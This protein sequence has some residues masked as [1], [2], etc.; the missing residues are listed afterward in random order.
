M[1]HKII[2]GEVVPKGIMP[3]GRHKSDRP[4]LHKG[5]SLP[6]A[7][8]E[9][10]GVPSAYINRYIKKL[11]ETEDVGLHTI[12]ILRHGHVIAEGAA[13]PYRTDCR[14]VVHSI[15]KSVTGMAIGLL[16]KEGKVALWEK[17][18]DI[19][20]EEAKDASEDIRSITVEQLLTMGTGVLFDEAHSIMEEDWVRAFFHSSCAFKPGEGFKYNS[21]NSYMLSAIVQKRTGETLL[22]YLKPRL[23]GPLGIRFVQWQ[24]CPKGIT[25]GGWGLALYLEDMAKLGQLYLNGGMWEV[26]GKMQEIIPPSWVERST[27]PQNWNRGELPKK[28][29]GYQLWVTDRG[30]LFNGMF[31]QYILVYPAHDMVIALT[32]GSQKSILAGE[33]L[34]VTDSFFRERRLFSDGPLP[35]NTAKAR[36]LLGL[37]GSME[38]FPGKGIPFGENRGFERRFLKALS[39]RVYRLSPFPLGGLL[40]TVVQCMQGRLSKGISAVSFFVK[41][42]ALELSFTEGEDTN[43]II[44]RAGEARPQRITLGGVTNLVSVKGSWQGAKGRPSLVLEFA[45]LE[46]SHTK[47]IILRFLSH[48]QLTLTIEESPSAANLLRAYNPLKEEKEGVWD[49][50]GLVRQAERYMNPRV[51]GV[52]EPPDLEK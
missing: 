12:M 27:R 26:D 51:R 41:E 14:Q 22:S 15:A 5:N 24:T 23:F 3:R 20:P 46:F 25:K 34:G 6:R 30:F 29:Y 31:G 38:A 4:I 13:A 39:G 9:E 17:I 7:L 40:P 43:A 33:A 37:L 36:R 1:L 52:L 48:E 18:S 50:R 28:R 45:F 35:K 42:G 10:M 32:S 2:R 47:T 8:P 49:K 11:L 21:M 16:E 19:F 44:L